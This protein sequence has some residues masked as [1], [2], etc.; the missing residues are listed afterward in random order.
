MTS[1]IFAANV[2]VL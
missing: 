2:V 1:L